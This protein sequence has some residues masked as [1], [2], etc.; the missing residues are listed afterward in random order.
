MTSSL[1]DSTSLDIFTEVL[2][3]SEP[4]QP[5]SNS[6]HDSNFDGHFANLV[7]L[8]KFAKNAIASTLANDQLEFHHKFITKYGRYGIDHCF[9]LSLLQL[10]EFPHLGW[11]IGRGRKRLPNNGVDILLTTNADENV[12]GIH[13]RLGWR[14]SSGGFF[15]ISTHRQGRT[16]LLN[17][18]ALNGEYRLVPRKNMITFGECLFRL[19][20]IDMSPKNEIQFQVELRTYM[21]MYCDDENPFVIPTPKE[22]DAAFGKWTVQWAIS[23]GA[24]GTVY[25]VIHS[26]SGEPAA[27]K[28]LL[29]TNRNQIAV[30]REIQMARL[31]SRFPHPRIACPLEII[32]QGKRTKVELDRIRALLSDEWDP[33]ASDDIISAFIIISPLSSTTLAYICNTLRPGSPGHL[34]YAPTTT[35]FLQLVEALAFL[36]GHGIAHR[37]VKPQNV[38]VN[39]LSPPRCVLTDFGS[40]SDQAVMPN[41]TVGTLAYLAPEQVPGREHSAAVDLWAA[42]LLGCQLMGLR[43]ESG[44][45]GERVG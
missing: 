2:G 17:G 13:A 41:A 40:A 25:M 10:P 28:H 14:Q 29:K 34:G 35:F 36:H 21:Q 6:L 19:E 26:D 7:P 37:D 32:T 5:Q 27:A 15:V 24:F 42:G 12:A 44:G 23:R 18:E 39:S 9:A 38:L 4:T 3:N 33:V 22:H 31:I 1:D 11:R 16:V 30:D 43:L 20:Y 8:N 45:K